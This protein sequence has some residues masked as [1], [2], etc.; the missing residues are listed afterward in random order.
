MQFKHFCLPFAMALRSTFPPCRPVSHFFLSFSLPASH[1]SHSTSPCLSC[2]PSPCVS[3]EDT[4][5]SW[6][7]AHFSHFTKCSHIQ[8]W[9]RKN[10]PAQHIDGI[11]NSLACSDLV[12]SPFLFPNGSML[13]SS[14]IALHFTIS[15]SKQA[16]ENLGP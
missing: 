16:L 1:L 7:S 8:R 4:P 5:F 12:P 15:T 2:S 9:R 13:A 14:Y 10:L 11:L 6:E 3:E